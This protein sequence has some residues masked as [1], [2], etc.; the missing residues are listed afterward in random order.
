MSEEE[1]RKIAQEEMA[2]QIRENIDSVLIFKYVSEL[3]EK[4]K[5]QD[6]IIDFMAETFDKLDDEDTYYLAGLGSKKEII[7]HFRNKA[8]GEKE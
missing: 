5:K 1:L 3:E 7:E 2:K 8:K 4:V 6:K